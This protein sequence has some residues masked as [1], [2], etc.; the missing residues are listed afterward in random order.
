[1]ETTI[2]PFIK[3]A[4]GKTQLLEVLKENFP[5]KEIKINRYIETFIGGGALFLDILSNFNNYNFDEIIIN[6]INTKLINTYI[7]LKEDCNQLIKHLNELKSIYQSL[8]TLEEKENYF[9]EVRNNFNDK[10]NTDEY[11]KSAELI[12]LNKTCFNGLYRENSKGLFNV[13]FGKHKDPSIF[14]ESHLKKISDLLNLKNSSGDDVVKILNLNFNELA[15]YIDQNTFVYFDPPYR[16]VTKNGFTSYDKSNFN[17]EAQILLAEF[18]KK[19]SSKKAYFLLS[20]SDPKNLDENDEFFD[21]LYKDFC[22][23]RVSAS[24]R[25][26]SKGSGRGNITEILVNNFKNISKNNLSF[27]KKPIFNITSKLPDYKL[28]L[29]SLNL[30]IKNP[31][32]KDDLKLIIK[33]LPRV[34]NILHF[35]IEFLMIN[36]INLIDLNYCKESINKLKFNFKDFETISDEELDK[37]IYF[38]EKSKLDLLLNTGLES[39]LKF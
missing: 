3:W 29:Y 9:Y 28:E 16:P 18:C 4:G 22:I 13:P 32:F 15:T 33:K 26:N 8:E 34:I 30:L 21:D 37:Y 35:I 23:N 24:R 39:N 12:F 17:D 14:D 31:N 10:N 5:P 6:D 38:I 27:D 20:N 7:C 19:I 36:D 25:I 11:I 2:K 1:M